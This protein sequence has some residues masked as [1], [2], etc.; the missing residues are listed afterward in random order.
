M[1]QDLN[2]NYNNNKRSRSSPPPPK[3]KKEEEDYKQLDLSLTPPT[4]LHAPSQQRP[5][6]P[7]LNSEES[8]ATTVS[9]ESDNYNYQPKLLN[10][11]H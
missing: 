9:F 8:A 10:L 1:K 5:G 4:F 7:S 6:T 2:G 3:F 11:F